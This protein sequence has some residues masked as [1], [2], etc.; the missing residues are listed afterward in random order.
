[1]R[2]RTRCFVGISVPLHTP[3]ATRKPTLY[4]IHRLGFTSQYLM[5]NTSRGGLSV[6]GL[7]HA[8][9][10]EHSRRHVSP[11]HTGFTVHKPPCRRLWMPLIHPPS[12]FIGNSKHQVGSMA[13]KYWF[14]VDLFV[15]SSSVY[16]LGS[17][18]D[19]GSLTGDGATRRSQ[20]TFP[21]LFQSVH[22]RKTMVTGAS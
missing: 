18:P 2:S 16:V 22:E 10:P 3:P 14:G 4:P 17:L 5:K 6:D 11:A 21:L 13:D 1:M 20:L 15:L 7:H 9:V 12:L 8:I 19:H